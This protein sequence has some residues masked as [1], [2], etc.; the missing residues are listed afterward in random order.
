MIF[1]CFGVIIG[2]LLSPLETYIHELGHCLG[3]FISTQK[4]NTFQEKLHIQ[5][6][7]TKSPFLFKEGK[8]KSNFLKFLSDNKEKYINI[9]SFIAFSG[10]LFSSIFY[11]VFIIISIY[12]RKYII[13]GL[14]IFFILREWL[15]FFTSKRN[16]S[17]IHLMIYPYS[18]YYNE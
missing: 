12:T 2:L 5:I 3:I 4:I 14:F 6:I 1:F 9:I 11:I 7:F 10:F 15:S 13:T 17:D 16:Q 18:F 8:T